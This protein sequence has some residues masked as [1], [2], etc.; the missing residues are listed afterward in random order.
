MVHGESF[1][2]RQLSD[3]VL[4]M[5]DLERESVN[6]VDFQARRCWHIPQDEP[7]IYGAITESW[8]RKGSGGS[9]LS[10]RFDD[11]HSVGEPYAENYFR[12][13]EAPPAFLGELEDH[14]E[15]GLV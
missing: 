12:Q 9:G 7:G 13:I 2:H 5:D 6:Q 15:R 8:S 14:G 4:S 3:D 1:G 11:L 10:F